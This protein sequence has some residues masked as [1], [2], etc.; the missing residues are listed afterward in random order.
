MTNERALHTF[1]QRLSPFLDVIGA[2]LI[3]GSWILSHALL[4]QAQDQANTHQ[5]IITLVRQF[6]LYDDFAQRISN[7]QSDLVRTRNLIEHANRGGNS[8]DVAAELPSET[9]TWTGM[10]STQM[11]EMTDFVQSLE[12]HAG[13]LS[14]SESV[15][16]AIENARSGVKEVSKAFET[17]RDE[18]DRLV[19]QR[20]MAVNDQSIIE[21]EQNLR[22]HLDRLW[23]NYDATKQS[24]LHVGDELLRT[25]AA[26]AGSAGRLANRFE[27]LS[28]G[29][30][31]VGT[32][33]VLYGRAKSVFSANKATPD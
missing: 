5:S 1:W 14:V 24:M 29:L 30:Y 31:I 12:R 3:F 28:W 21:Q 15:T 13:Q 20:D 6:R 27:R 11:R 7:I 9:L 23:Q 22:K 4:Q 26:E 19:E 32:L 25:A 33:I 10:T 2:V 8:S 18:F 17:D 16:L